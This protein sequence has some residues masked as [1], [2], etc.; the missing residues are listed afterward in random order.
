MTL[1][2]GIIGC[3]THAAHHAKHYGDDFVTYG[4]WDPDREAMERIKSERKCLTLETLLYSSEIDAVLI[5]S[6]DQ[7]HLEQIEKALREGKHVYC[8]KPLAV[9]GQD[10]DRLRNA[11]DIAEGKKLV[12]TTCHPRRFDRPFIWL[13]S[14]MHADPALDLYRGLFGKV[15]SFDF[16]FSY[17]KPS[18]QWKHTRSLL[19]D[20]LNHEIDLLNFLFGIQGFDAWQ[21]Y[22]GFD[23]Y[24]VVGMRDGI[25]FHFRGTRRLDSHIYPEWCR[26]RFERAEVE[27][28]MMRGVAHISDHEMKTVTTEPDLSIDYDGR[29]RRAMK[30]FHRQIEVVK[31]GIRTE[32][33]EQPLTRAEMLMNTEAGIVLQNKGVQRINIRP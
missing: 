5:C 23:R 31:F 30:D 13:K 21:L 1:N 28:D 9:P 11:F 10:I 15:I 22:D 26:V 32:S 12:L 29:L 7:F 18:N 3:G 17:H 33:S 19:L 6:P 20:H 2:I 27:I 25:A 14:K 24:E 4:V 8:E 16:D